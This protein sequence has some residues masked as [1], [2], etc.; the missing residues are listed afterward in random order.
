MLK[1]LPLAILAASTV[2]ASFAA[3]N[4]VQYNAVDAVVIQDNAWDNPAAIANTANQVAVSDQD[5]AGVVF[6]SGSQKIG[7]HAGNVAGNSFLAD[8]EG[9]ANE[10]PVGAARGLDLFWGMG[11]QSKTGVRFGYYT[12]NDKGLA[13][14]GFGA[15]SFADTIFLTEGST[16]FEDGAG[17]KA[18]ITIAD[19]KNV[20]NFTKY[21]LSFGQ[22]LPR[23]GFSVNLAMPT[24]NNQEL[25]KYTTVTDQAA[26]GAPDITREFTSNEQASSGFSYEASA[27]F[28]QF[29]SRSFYVFGNGA[30]N[31]YNTNVVD[32]QRV[33]IK[34]PETDDAV[35]ATQTTSSDNASV[36]RSEVGAGLVQRTAT[37]TMQ[38]KGS[39]VYRRYAETTQDNTTVT[40]GV[41]AP[42]G[43]DASDSVTF[44]SFFL[45]VEASIEGSKEGSAFTW[46]AGARANLL[47]LINQ[48]VTEGEHNPDADNEKYALDYTKINVQD[49]D[50]AT[51]GATVSL[52]M[53]WSPVE[54]LQVNGVINQLFL[55]DSFTDNGLVSRISASYSF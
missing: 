4:F 49:S 31:S 13:S 47:T 21:E 16:T 41:E 29:F 5:T 28:K 54:G 37:T 40:E 22:I 38:I 39:F 14:V 26:D 3:D 19:N 8:T 20:S 30:Y 33:V 25:L 23:G 1:K 53:G 15:P 9:G 45:P 35:T 2:G 48:K 43:V 17:N 6:N 46:R 51:G 55:T 34:V 18:T 42:T 12:V 44:N 27:G 36:I 11:Q 24:F 7:I 52:G 10:N 32:E 50:M